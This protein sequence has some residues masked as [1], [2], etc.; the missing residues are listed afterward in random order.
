MI[1]DEKDRKLIKLLS[2][3]AN[4][5]SSQISKKT[6]IPITTVHN[7]IQKLKESRIIKKYTVLLDYEK[8]GCPLKA[9]ILVSV[10]QSRVS[11]TKIGKQLKNL[12]GVESV[13]IVTGATDMIVEM[14]VK[15]MHILNELIT[16]RIRK[17]EGIDKT[18]T[19]MAL[20][21]IE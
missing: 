12:E 20:E 1:I 9:F 19:L 13:D 15:D 17:I 8:V 2:S 7:R 5:T 4:L 21:E 16:E 11:Q 6:G 3:E 18:Q 14:R 10:N